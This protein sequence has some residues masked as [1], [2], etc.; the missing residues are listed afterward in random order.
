MTATA[1]RARWIR[2]MD[3]G[4]I[5]REGGPLAPY[6]SNP[7]IHNL[8]FSIGKYACFCLTE[9]TKLREMKM[10]FNSDKIQLQLHI[11]TS[12][13]ITL[14]Y[15]NSSSRLRFLGKSNDRMTSLCRE[16]SRSTSD[17]QLSMEAWSNFDVAKIKSSSCLQMTG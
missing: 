16:R 6:F 11:L 8:L 12:I 9:A 7:H 15:R 17:M 1:N 13:E 14:S 5:C 2:R 3:I 4:A 10:F